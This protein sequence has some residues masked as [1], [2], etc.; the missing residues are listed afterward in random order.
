LA[1]LILVVAAFLL[2][3]SVVAS[4]DGQRLDF[5]LFESAEPIGEGSIDPRP[6]AGNTLLLQFWASWC[7]SCGSLMWDMDELATANDGVTY[8]AVSIDDAV[9]DARTYIRKHRLYEKYSDRYFVDSGKALSGSLD[10]TTVPT[11]FL[12]DAAGN[13]LVRKSGHLNGA[14]LREFVIAMDRK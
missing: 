2:V 4:D 11:I 14:D 8:V 3:A 9:E 1:R 10:V 12:V 7:H 5:A 6:L 13:V